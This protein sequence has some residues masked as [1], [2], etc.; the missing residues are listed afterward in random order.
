MPLSS[1]QVNIGGKRALSSR[2]LSHIHLFHLLFNLFQFLICCTHWDQNKYHTFCRRRF[3]WSLW[4]E[5]YCILIRHQSCMLWY[6]NVQLY[7]QCLPSVAS[8]TNSPNMCIDYCLKEDM[9]L[10]YA[11]L[12]ENPTPCT[13]VIIVWRGVSHWSLDNTFRPR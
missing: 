8:I 3:R 13:S 10:I 5:N 2:P 11:Y 4:Y 1:L 12:M 9:V 6:S 7:L